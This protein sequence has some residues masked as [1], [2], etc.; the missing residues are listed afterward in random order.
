MAQGKKR[1]GEEKCIS[2]LLAPM[3]GKRGLGQGSFP[4]M[5]RTSG[6]GNT[7]ES[8]TQIWKGDIKSV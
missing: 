8:T 2:S 3:I 6:P 1:R 7:P 4:A 5:R